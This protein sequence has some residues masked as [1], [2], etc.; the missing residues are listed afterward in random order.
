M[1][2]HQQGDKIR[3]RKG[4]FAGKR[5][6]LKC[7]ESEGWIVFLD[8]ERNEVVIHTEDVTN[9]SLAARRAWHRMPNR[10]VGR[11]SGTK[12]TDRISVIFR[13]DRELWEEFVAAEQI[14]LVGDRTTFI[15]N[16][17]R[18][19]LLSAKRRRSLL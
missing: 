14:G 8:N 1:S 15:N 4:P 10:N 17:L 6:V 12:V 7:Q 18:Q 13:V 11:P 5:G 19:H 3:V 2:Q 9:Y 16:C